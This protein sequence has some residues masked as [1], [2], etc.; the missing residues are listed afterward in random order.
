[1]KISKVPEHKPADAKD[2]VVQ[3]SPILPCPQP[4]SHRLLSPR[5]DGYSRLEVQWFDLQTQGI[6]CSP[7]LPGV[8]ER[9]QTGQHTPVAGAQ[10]AKRRPWGIASRP[11]GQTTHT[12]APTPSQEQPSLRLVSLPQVSAPIRGLHSEPWVLLGSTQHW[13][14]LSS[15]RNFIQ[16]FWQPSGGY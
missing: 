4:A 8:Q 13:Q 10:Q 2:S 12:T 5:T 6:R 3:C 9:W 7:Q 16:S 15:H 1:M 11:T 14:S